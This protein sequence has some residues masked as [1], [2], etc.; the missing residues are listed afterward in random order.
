MIASKKFPEAKQLAR[1]LQAEDGVP[2]DITQQAGGLIVTADEEFKKIFANT[3]W[4]EEA[5]EV[6]GETKKDKKRRNKEKD[7]QG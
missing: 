6:E 2:E 4:K 1:N 5:I 3:E 7:N